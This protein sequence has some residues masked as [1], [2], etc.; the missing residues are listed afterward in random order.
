LEEAKVLLRNHRIVP[1]KM[2]GQNF[3]VDA[4][5]YAELASYAALTAKDTVLDAG[6]GFGFLTRFLANKCKHVLAVE[7][8]PRLAQVLREQV[9]DLANVEV[10]EG[11]VL[12]ARIPLFNKT[13]SAPPYYLSSQ[14]VLWLIDRGF[15]AAVLVVQK[16][17]ANR[18]AAPVD[19]QEYGWLAVVV[20][21][22][23]EAELLD[24]VPRWMFHPE[25]EVDS[26]I[27]RLKPWATPPFTIKNAKLF[28]RVT[29]YLFTERN[30]KL[31]NAIAP[32]MRT[33]LK[34]DKAKATEMAAT[35]PLA[36]KRVRELIP[37][38]F[39]AIADALS[40]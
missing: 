29:K 22:A 37:R 25:P 35:L 5:T 13:V 18:L 21:Q 17:F 3:M 11:D 40:K 33:E 28:K 39:G 8:D 6:A 16:E 7:K 19:S 15:D 4:S 27:L 10:I 14:L 36:K 38:D 9:C 1:N 34:V 20:A 2:L 32:F 23:A 26:I 24:E 30:K 31:Q 12:K